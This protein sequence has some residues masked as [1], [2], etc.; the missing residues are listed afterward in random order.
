MFLEWLS[1]SNTIS[2]SMEIHV[3]SN[4]IQNIYSSNHF[5]RNLMSWWENQ[6]YLLSAKI[7]LNQHYCLSS[8]QTFRCKHHLFSSQLLLRVFNIENSTGSIKKMLWTFNDLACIQLRLIERWT[9]Q[10]DCYLYFEMKILSKPKVGISKLRNDSRN[11][12]QLCKR[13]CS[14]W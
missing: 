1:A 10:D 11:D 12:Y 13:I 8:C 5:M 2:N 3:I 4:K 9:R 6:S 7:N 14:L